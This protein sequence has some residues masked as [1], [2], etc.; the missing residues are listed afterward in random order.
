MHAV[1]AR[2][3]HDDPSKRFPTALAFVSA[4][5]AA[6]RG[7]TA[8]APA[9]LAP[10][11][12]AAAPVVVPPLVAPAPVVPPEPVAAPEPVVKKSASPAPPPAVT[13]T[14]GE[15]EVE[16]ELEPAPL[17]TTGTPGPQLFDADDDDF[18]VRVR[19][20]EDAAAP[21]ADLANEPAE[22]GQFADAL[23]EFTKF[24]GEQAAQ[25]ESRRPLE[26]LHETIPPVPF[27]SQPPMFGAAEM[28][29]DG[30]DYDE[31][32]RLRM[33]PVA[34]GFVLGLLI[35]FGI[36]HF[37][38]RQSRDAEVTPATGTSTPPPA[39][40]GAATPQQPG[41]YSEQKVSPPAATPRQQPPATAPPIPNEAPST[42]ARPSA[43]AP[44][45]PTRGRL[46]VSS[47]PSRGAV[48]VNG[49]WRGRTPLTLDSLPFGRYVIR[50]VLPGYATSR[51]ELTLSARDASQD[52]RARLAPNPQAA[53]PAPSAAPTSRT[54]AKPAPANVFTGSLYVDSRPRGATVYLDGRN[55]GQTPLSL[56]EVPIGAHVVRLELTGKRTWTAST[57]VVAGEMARVTGSLEDRNE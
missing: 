51:H 43:A 38:G 8:P 21:V 31:R 49:V 29:R 16:R 23:D 36:G 32:P 4:L 34:L 30:R 35:G 18:D 5:E 41:Q 52:V 19:E 39:A 46:V 17:A 55:V 9:V 2:A 50:I 57:R 37:M 13:P 7:E 54:P 40:T 11:V 27:A 25:A 26:A 45:A 44:A 1:L 6:G 33:L 56:P 20:E 10:P 14:P 48:T 15:F 12:A 28:E 3:M 24:S 47:T 22:P 42:P 53:R